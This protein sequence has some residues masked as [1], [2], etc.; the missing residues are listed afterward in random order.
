MTTAKHVGI[1]FLTAILTAIVL[2]AFC[3]PAGERIGHVPANVIPVG[4]PVAK[5]EPLQASALALPDIAT[6]THISTPVADP[7]TP[8]AYLPADDLCIALVVFAEA[9][10]ESYLGQAVVASTVRTRAILQG[11]SECDVVQAYG[12]YVMTEDPWLTDR[13]EWNQ[14]AS[15]AIEVS[16]GSPSFGPCDGAT[17]FHAKSVYPAWARRMTHICDV[18]NHSFYK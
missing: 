12:Q 13:V 4:Y 18:G 14:S 10:G 16:D 7:W 2:I 1:V 8:E 17:H 5:V 15:A 11:V 6:L 3:Y 9:R